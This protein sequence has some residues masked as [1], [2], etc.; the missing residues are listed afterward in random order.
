MRMRGALLAS[1]L[2]AV[3]PAT[4]CAQDQKN[5]PQGVRIGL[6]YAAGTKPGVIILPF[7]RTGGDSIGTIV[8]RDLDYSDRVNV[9]L[10]DSATIK[11]LTPGANRKI[12]YALMSKF[13]ASVLIMGSRTVAGVRITVFDVGAKKQFGTANFVLPPGEP[14]PEWRFAVHGVSDEIERWLLGVRGMAQS[15]IA[16]VHAGA[17][18]LVDSDGAVTRTIRAGSGSLSPSWSFDGTRLV[19]CVLGNNGTQIY[20]A[21]LSTGNISRISSVGIGLNITPVFTADGNAI[22]YSHGASEGS[23]L[24]MVDRAG[25]AQR[26]T[27]GNGADN[28]SPSFSPDGSQLAFISGRSGVP[29]VY[30]MDADGTNMTLLTGYDMAVPSY[31]SSPDWSPDGRAIAYQQRAAGGFQVWMIDVRSRVPRQLTTDGENEDPSW[32]PDG[33]HIVLTSTRGGDKQL[34]VLDSESG[35]FRQL[36]HSS[37]ARLAS[38][39]PLL[40]RQSPPLAPK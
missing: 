20:E 34:W 9:I 26:L 19:Y 36:T 16:F 29:Q 25:N 32:A 22:V 21:D 10:L 17:I 18:K 27:V 12:N 30:I 13:G 8:S 37:G 23:D 14:F 31:R 5:P 40:G 38:W 35:R 11:A 39:S 6:N 7:E 28:N 33:R 2:V 24:V 4:A 15:R 3:L 1:I